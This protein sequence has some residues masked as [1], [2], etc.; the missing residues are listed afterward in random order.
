MPLSLSYNLYC[1]AYPIINSCDFNFVSI[2]RKKLSTKE[3]L[4]HSLF[5][6][7]DF[8]STVLSEISK[9]IEPNIIQNLKDIKCFPVF[10]SSEIYQL[11][12]KNTFLIED[13]KNP[14]LEE[15]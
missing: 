3:L 15:E 13:L 8:I 11:K 4:D 6:N 2:L 12:N 9:K 1:V 5:K 14:Y 7:K 10:V